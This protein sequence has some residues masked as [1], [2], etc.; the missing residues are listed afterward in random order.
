[1]SR[2]SPGSAQ[3]E[4]R[5]PGDSVHAGTMIHTGMVQVL[6]Q[7]VGEGTYMARIVVRVEESLANRAEA[8]K[9]A[10]LLAARL[11]TLG[12]VSTGFTAMLTRDLSKTLSVLLAMASPCATVL[13][14]STAVTAGLANAARNGVFV[15][16]GLYLERFREIDCTCFDKTG[17]VTSEIPT[18]VEIIP[19]KPET[20]P[21]EILG[22]AADSTAAILTP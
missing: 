3:P 6:A 2:T 19:M 18:M 15:K 9:R 13:A 7:D 17:T 14:A 10:D 22:L 21:R 4:Y 8:E 11:T 12:L 20:E 1:M 16:G 5:K